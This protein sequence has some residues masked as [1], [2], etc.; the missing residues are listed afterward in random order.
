MLNGGMSSNAIRI[1]TQV[2]PQ[3]M[4]SATSSSRALAA[5]DRLLGIEDIPVR[6]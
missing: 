2:V 4:Q 6:A 1:V 5:S 3:P